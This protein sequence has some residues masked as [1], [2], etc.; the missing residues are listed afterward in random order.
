MSEVIISAQKRETAGTSISRSL[1]RSG[2]VPAV[3]YG[4]HNDAVAVSVDRLELGRLLRSD[5]SIIT[6]DLDGKKE[7]AVIKEVQ[8]HPV[9][10]DVLHV[11]FMRVAAGSEIKVTVPINYIGESAGV[12]LGGL[13]SIMKNELTMQ[14][15][16]KNM[17]DT[18]EVD[19]TDME[20]GD[21]VRVGD[22][23]LKD[24]TIL[25]D[26][27]VMLCQ[28]HVTRKAAETLTE[29]EEEE[30]GEVEDGEAPEEG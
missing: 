19:I 18:I 2:R 25:D 15:L 5:F 6:I 21:V 22:L 1:R 24:V 16:P 27:A 17:P 11:D 14:V 23:D 8:V 26:P 10:S 29:G 20:I 28:V 7:Q 30:T 4:A 12:K 13:L 9:R 3:V